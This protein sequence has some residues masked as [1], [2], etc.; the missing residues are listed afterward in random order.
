MT[1]QAIVEFGPFRL[2]LAHPR[3]WRDEVK[4]ELRP[5]SLAVLGYLVAHAD[6]VVTKE[7]LISQVW[8]G[9]QV[10]EVS[11]RV[12]VREI[13]QALGETAAAPRHL[14]GSGAN[15]KWKT[16][17]SEFRVVSHAARTASQTC[18]TRAPGEQR[19]ERSNWRF[20]I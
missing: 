1:Q 4:V 12:C 14:Q 6:R 3:L 15:Y 8:A 5:M 18:G 13:R 17:E 2:D 9:Q 10:S 19:V 11:V 7:E 20:L 16:N